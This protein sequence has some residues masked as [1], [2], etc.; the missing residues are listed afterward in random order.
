MR[1]N[2]Y[3]ALK[4]ISTRRDADKLVANKKVFINDKLA[5]LGS[6]VNKNDVVE[7]KNYKPKECIYFAYHKPVGIETNSPKNDLFPL[8]RLDN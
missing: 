7:V 5:I 8:G 6:K 3:L 1:I 2:K 4:K